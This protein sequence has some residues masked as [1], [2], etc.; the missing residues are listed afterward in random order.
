MLRTPPPLTAEGE[1]VKPEPEK[2][3]LQK[4]WLYI[5]AAMFALR[6]S[7]MLFVLLSHS[8]YAFSPNRWG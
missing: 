8:L 1:P 3:F 2:T 4:Y 5:V 7:R 6:K